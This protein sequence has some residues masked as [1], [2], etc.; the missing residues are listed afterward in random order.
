MGV[1]MSV[2]ILWHLMHTPSKPVRFVPSRTDWSTAHQFYP[3]KSIKPLPTD[4]PQRLPRVQADASDFKHTET[5]ERRQSVIRQEFIRS[6]RAYKKHAW[7]MDELTPLTGGGKNTFGGWAATLV[8]SLDTMWIM[9]LDEEFGEAAAAAA[10]LDWSDIS[11]GAVNLF[12]TTIRHLGGLLSAY[13]L[14]HK[15]ALLQKAHELGN[16]L[17][18]AFDTPNRLPGFWLNFE[19]AKTGK[20]RAGVH[21]PSASPASLTLEMTRLSQL[22]GDPKFY[23]AADR[24]TQFLAKVQNDTLIPGMWPVSLDFQNEVARYNKFSLG[25]L[26]DSLYEYLPKMHALMGGI[27]PTYEILYRA[28]A[29]A[30]MENLLFRPM[31]PENEDILFLGDVLINNKEKQLISE[32]QHLTC[33]AG[34]MFALGGRLLDVKQH[35]EVGEQLARGCGW[36]YRSF[37]T[38][39]MPEIFDILPCPSLEPCVWD[40]AR[41][42]RDGDTRLAKGFRNARDPRYILR[43]EAIESIFIMYRITADPAWQELAWKMWTSISEATKTE[44]ANAAIVDVTNPVSPKVDSMEVCSCFPPRISYCVADKVTEL[45]AS[46]D[47]QIFLPHLFTP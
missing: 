22:T 3:P 38:G 29:D 11:D 33:F 15:E 12:E 31:V 34:G 1:V 26:A 39:V 18:A 35:V 44:F 37:V 5:S 21:D 42:Q 17:Y 24:V 20:Q 8:D 13:E 25:A 30:V 4:R 9:G 2:M 45:L 28:S 43:P 16:M 27:D 10:A 19:E 36:A 7:M 6:Y 14:S 47:T 23:D 41:W 40:E 46:G 32:S